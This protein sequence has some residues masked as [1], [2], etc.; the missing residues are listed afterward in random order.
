MATDEYEGCTLTSCLFRPTDPKSEETMNESRVKEIAN[1][2]NLIATRIAAGKAASPDLDHIKMLAI[3]IHDLCD[4]VLP[5]PMADHCGTTKACESRSTLNPNVCACTCAACDLIAL[6]CG[7]RAPSPPEAKTGARKKKTPEHKGHAC[8]RCKKPGAG[9]VWVNGH[10]GIYCP[11]CATEL[12]VAGAEQ[13][14]QFTKVMEVGETGMKVLDGS[15]VPAKIERVS[16]FDVESAAAWNLAMARALADEANLSLL[17]D[18]PIAVDEDFAEAA[19]AVF[20]TH[21][22]D[23]ELRD[24]MNGRQGDNLSRFTEMLN[25]KGIK[26]GLVDVCGWTQLAR[27]VAQAWLDQGGD[28]PEFLEKC[29][30][31]PNPRGERRFIAVDLGSGTAQDSGLVEDG[32]SAC[33]AGTPFEEGK[34]YLHTGTGGGCSP[35]AV[36]AKYKEDDFKAFQASLPPKPRGRGR[37]KGSK[38]K[39]KIKDKWAEAAARANAKEEAT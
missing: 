23:Q 17:D 29:Q 6:S 11:E 9:D 2:A 21:P 14:Q 25:A 24:V 36:A 39:P 32:C 5:K 19:R 1:T 22:V 3:L 13:V 34:E 12:M 15:K 20:G 28:V 37:P 31:T 35:D 18:E 26:V 38:N 10:S 33:N 7:I 16:M 30:S 8:E 4:A 27:D